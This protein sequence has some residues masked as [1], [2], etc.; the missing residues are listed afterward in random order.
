MK[1]ASVG[2]GHKVVLFMRSSVMQF[3]AAFFVF[4]IPEP[5]R[6]DITIAMGFNP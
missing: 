5:Q 1:E 4:S 6:G 3:D 2:L